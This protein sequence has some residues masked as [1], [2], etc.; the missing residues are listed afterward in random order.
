MECGARAGPST[1]G[2]AVA[3]K[4]FLQERELASRE[5]RAPETELRLRVPGLWAQLDGEHRPVPQE[6]G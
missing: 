3:K 6:R 2:E 4:S 5:G 1:A